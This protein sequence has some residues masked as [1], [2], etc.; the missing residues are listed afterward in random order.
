MLCALLVG[1]SSAFTAVVEGGT[2]ALLQLE[3]ADNWWERQRGLMYRS[4]LPEG[5]GMLLV[6][7]D[8][9]PRRVWMKNTRIP[10]DILFLS[11]NG[12]ILH[13]VSDAVPCSQV[14]CEIYASPMP[15]RYV[16]EVNAGFIQQYAVKVGDRVL[17]PGTASPAEPGPR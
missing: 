8:E 6:F 9:G 1:R 15:A 10:L 12:T 14:P 11:G 5:S 17:F 3:I 2:P 4:H 7:E 16:L 13:L